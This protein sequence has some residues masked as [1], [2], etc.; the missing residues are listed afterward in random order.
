[1]D[2]S[3]GDFLSRLRAPS[4]GISLIFNILI[5]EEEGMFVAHCLELD[6]VATGDTAG[7]AQK[8]LVALIC[9]QV[10]YAF[11]NDNLENLYHPA[12]PEIWK[13]FFACKEASEK[14]YRIDSG[15]RREVAPDVFVPPWLIAKTCHA[16]KTCYV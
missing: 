15:F 11:S 16:P 2:R 6:V 4:K 3:F 14:R 1:M 9:T 12:P 8:D 13:L 10:D 5:K 7:S